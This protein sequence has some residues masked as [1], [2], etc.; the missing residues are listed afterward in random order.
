[1]CRRI[2]WFVSHQ[3]NPF[4]FRSRTSQVDIGFIDSFPALTYLHIAKQDSLPAGEPPRFKA[5][6]KMNTETTKM[7]G[8]RIFGNAEML[9]AILLELPQKDVLL[10]QAVCESWQDTTQKSNEGTESTVFHP[11]K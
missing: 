9:E 6:M 7:S 2:C 5:G 3:P 4:P 1:M 11:R 8:H 10:S